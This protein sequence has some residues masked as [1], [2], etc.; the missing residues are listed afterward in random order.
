[1]S[2]LSIARS[3]AIGLNPH[4]LG[5][6]IF[7]TEKCN[8]RCLY[9]YETFPNIRM[10]DAVASALTKLI[11]NRRSDLDALSIRW[12]GGEP[13]LEASRV[14]E[15]STFAKKV[16]VE[17]DIDFWSGITTNGFLLTYP[18][19]VNLLEAGICH[20]QVSLD[21]MKTEHDATRRGHTDRGTFDRIIRNL[22]DFR[23]ESWRRLFGQ[24]P[25]GFKWIPAGLC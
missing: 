6:T 14:I 23:L 19:F 2:D 1:M 20:F 8:F 15:L 24:R 22:L 3:R 21:G 13:L 10:S 4:V 5:L 25:A 12:F 11:F 17:N 18:L 16:A 9:C 7:P